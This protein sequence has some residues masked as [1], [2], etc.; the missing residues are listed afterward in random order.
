M[1]RLIFLLVIVFVSACIQQN[2]ESP[3]YEKQYSKFLLFPTCHWDH[4]PLKVLIDIDSGY[5]FGGFF[6]KATELEHIQDALNLWE[7]KTNNTI[8]FVEVN[9]SPDITIRYTGAFY[10]T[11]GTTWKTA[12]E[13]MPV[14]YENGA[15]KSSEINLTLSSMDCQNKYTIIHELGHSLC[16]GHSNSSTFYENGKW[17]NDIMAWYLTCDEPDISPEMS[18]A[19]IGIE[20]NI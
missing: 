6:D 12:G 7:S 20:K 18:R 13:S 14:V 11:G 15:I 8:R 1:N 9:E 4:M 2:Q 16:L 17:K 10:E 3:F 19:L 5:K